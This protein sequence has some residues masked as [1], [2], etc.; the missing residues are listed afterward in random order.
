[1]LAKN[2]SR[3]ARPASVAKPRPHSARRMCQPSSGTCTGRPAGCIIGPQSPRK[4]PVALACHR[5]K[6]RAVVSQARLGPAHPRVPSRRGTWSTDRPT[7][8][9]GLAE[10]LEQPVD[11]VGCQ[12][13]QRQPFRL[14][15]G[16]RAGAGAGPNGAPWPRTTTTISASPSMISEHVLTVGDTEPS[17]RTWNSARSLH[18]PKHRYAGQGQRKGAPCGAPFALLSERERSW[19]WFPLFTSSWQSACRRLLRVFRACSYLISTLAP[20]SSRAALILSASSLATP[21]LTA[22]GR[23]VDQV[24]GLLEAQAGQLAD[25]LDDLDLVRADLGQHS[26]ELRLLLFGG[27]RGRRHRRHHRRPEPRRLPWARRP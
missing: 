27:G 14:E 15:N 11:V 2:Q 19:G 3:A 21:S 12:L 10:N 23:R 7:W 1:M 8:L 13:A 22:F 26:V 6:A 25:D 16:H 9:L 17:S 24:L 4:S 5:P 20:C 18:G